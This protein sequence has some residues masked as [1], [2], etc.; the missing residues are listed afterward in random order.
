MQH[1]LDTLTGQNKESLKAHGVKLNQKHL[2]ITEDIK[3]EVRKIRPNTK[4]VSHSV[5]YSAFLEYYRERHYS[6]GFIEKV[7]EISDNKYLKSTSG[8]LVYLLECKI[9]ESKNL[10]KIGKSSVK[11]INARV[12]AVKTG[13]SD[14]SL[15]QVSL[16]QVNQCLSE[17]FFFQ[18]Y[19]EFRTKFG[20]SEGKTEWFEFDNA[21]LDEVIKDF[22]FGKDLE[23]LQQTLL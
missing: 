18:K 12:E 13:L 21:A 22:Q 17:S 23:P 8:D 4:V 15:A 14:Y 6:H 3:N 16:I 10:Y 7:C 11:N 1:I 19:S 20:E 9:N 2:D 5:I